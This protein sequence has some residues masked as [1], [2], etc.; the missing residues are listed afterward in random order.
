[1]ASGSEI[2]AAI[3]QLREATERT[4][5]VER[6]PAAEVD[7]ERLVRFSPDLP[8]TLEPEERRRLEAQAAELDPWLQGPFLLGGDLV[9]GGAWRCDLRWEGLGQR[10]P[11]SLQG[12]KVLDVGS[13]A[14]YDAFMFKHR[15]ADDV[16]ACEPFAFFRQ[17]EFLESIY[18]IGVDLRQLGWQGLDADELGRFDIVHCNGVLYHEPHPIRMLQR[19]RTVVADDGQLLIGSM[20]LPDPELSE[21]VRFVAGSYAGDPTWWWVP[22]RLALR[23]MLE[24]TGFSVD[25]EFNTSEGPRGQF[26]VI[27]AYLRCTPRESSALLAAAELP[28]R[29]PR[30]RFPAGHYYSPFP[31]VL[32]LGEEPRRSQVWPTAPHATPG[33]DWRDGEQVALCQES[34]AQQ[35]RLALRTEPSDDPTEF[36]AANDQY[37]PLDAWILE[38]MLRTFR[39][40]QMIEVGSGFSSLVTARVNR[41]CFDSELD[42]T[43]IEPYPR[44]FL[45]AGVPGISGLRIEE[46]QNTP[47]EIIEALGEND[48]LFI[49]TS[50]TVKTGGDVP[51]LFNQVLPRLRSGVLVHVHDVFL[52][53]DY[54]QQWVLEGWGWNELYLVEAFLAFNS[55]FRIVF[56]AQYMIQRHRDVLLEGFPGFPEHE[57]RGGAALWMQRV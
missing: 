41:E 38:A 55:A 23:W 19:L 42:F 13:N 45:L 43:C 24:S 51:W 35:K 14:G 9:V 25:E 47:L 11:A 49:D 53:G 31:D 5:G 28:S 36:H 34:F 3:Q 40:A 16:V 32:K 8:D 21:Y 1:M 48:V 52:P 33:T 50:H 4:L 56:G 37:P 29:V 57:E 7:L 22:G 30:P 10:L 26:S 39:P 20:M 12:L 44:E 27:N 17:A 54:P 2:S 6:P 18:R 15:G 46:I